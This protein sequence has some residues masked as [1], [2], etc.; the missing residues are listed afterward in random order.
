LSFKTGA[1]VSRNGLPRAAL[2]RVRDALAP[3]G[4]VTRVRPLR[5][6]ISS[7]VHLVHLED[8]VGERHAVVVRRYGEYWQRVDPA[9]C[10]REFQLL[11]VLARSSFPAPRPLLLDAEG[12]PFGAPTVVM[13]RLPGRPLLAPR[14]LA[15][16]L[17]QLAHTLV[18]L[19]KQPTHELEFLPDQAAMVTRVLGQRTETDDPLQRAIREAAVA[20]W[21]R[22]ARSEARRVLV[23]GDYWPGNLLWVRGRL[24][25]V[26]D[27]EQ[28]R[29]GDLAKDVATCRGD[30]W[31]LFG[32]A[33][34]DDFLSE[35]ERAAGV[36]VNDLAF[37]DLLISSWAVPE[38]EEWAVAYRILGR[39]DL[40]PEVASGRIRAFARAA[41]ERL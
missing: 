26:V 40:T 2:D 3:D 22:I 39:P 20:E 19:H 28:P 33:A 12:G 6:G 23:H 16:Y 25:G 31:V 24:I 11:E 5:G 32:Q 18:E 7:S 37:W 14:D 1:N 13:T 8:T 29:L 10:A 36:K 21:S 17:R 9:A 35:Y 38:M 4:Q 41:L 15:S 34:A 30:L 27:W